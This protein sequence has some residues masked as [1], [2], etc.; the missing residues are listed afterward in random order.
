MSWPQLDGIDLVVTLGSDWSAYWEHVG[1]SV[2]AEMALVRAV[3]Q[4]H[5][6]MLGIC[7]GAQV[8][9]QA[10]GGRVDRAPEPE[11][12]WYALD[13]TAGAPFDAGP[14]FQWH[15]DRFEP[16]AS[17]TVLA[18]TPRAVQAFTIGRMLA[19]QF[20]PE[21]TPAMVGRWSSGD[22]EHELKRL[23]ADRAAVVAATAHQAPQRRDAAGD[24]VEWVLA[25]T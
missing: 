10:L 21:V 5:R 8:A 15:A 23:G 2:E 25:S 17:A 4:Q 22:G 24:M 6:P 16:P 12:G 20:H 3:Q 1:V 13:V 18:R 9:A 11:V 7:F 14:W 19:V